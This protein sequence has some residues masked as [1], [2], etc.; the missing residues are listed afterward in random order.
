MNIT[1]STIQY[2]LGNSVKTFKIPKEDRNINFKKWSYN[3]VITYIKLIEQKRNKKPKNKNNKV[4]YAKLIT[5]KDNMIIK[6]KKTADELKTDYV[7][8]VSKYGAESIQAKS[9]L[10]QLN[11]YGDKILKRYYQEYIKTLRPGQEFNLT[12][13]QLTQKLNE[14]AKYY[15]RDLEC[16]RI[17]I[18]NSMARKDVEVERIQYSDSYNFINVLGRGQRMIAGFD[19]NEKLYFNFPIVNK[20]TLEDVINKIKSEVNIKEFKNFYNW[21]DDKS[22]INKKDIDKYKND[23][24][25]DEKFPPL[26]I[27]PTETSIYICGDIFE[28]LMSKNNGEL[29]KKIYY[30]QY[31]NFGG[32]KYFI[33]NNDIIG[34]GFIDYFMNDEIEFNGNNTDIAFISKLIDNILERVGFTVSRYKDIYDSKEDIIG[35]DVKHK[36]EKGDFDKKMEEEDDDKDVYKDDTDE[37][38]ERIKKKIEEYERNKRGQNEKITPAITEFKPFE[39]PK[40]IEPEIITEEIKP[41]E[42]E[43]KPIDPKR[44][45]PKD[46]KNTVE[47][48]P[49][50][51]L[52]PP[53]NPIPPPL[54]VPPVKP[55]TPPVIP[56]VPQVEPI[57]P[58]VIPEVQ[59]VIPQVEDKQTPTYGP[60]IP[61][62]QNNKIK[63]DVICITENNIVKVVGL[64]VM[65]GKKIEAETIYDAFGPS[66]S[67][68]FENC[69]SQLELYDH[70]KLKNKDVNQQLDIYNDIILKYYNY[71]DIE[72]IFYIEY[73]K[74]EA[75]NDL[76]KQLNELDE[77]PEHIINKIESNPK[78]V[79]YNSKQGNGFYNAGIY[80]SI[81]DF[82]NFRKDTKET[83][84]YLL[85]RII[86]L[87]KDMKTV[88]NKLVSNDIR[89][90]LRDKNIELNNEDD[91]D[92]DTGGNGFMC[93]RCGMINPKFF[94]NDYP[95]LSEFREQFSKL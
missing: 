2:I 6:G 23:M 88:K 7:L 10:E 78:K 37:V 51:P 34:V 8:A 66:F 82:I 33:I 77:N 84:Y 64:I 48:T 65:N 13:E 94:K 68:N 3:D 63:I 1:N 11:E 24:I 28:Y 81:K 5:V 91:E 43:E 80:D 79:F 73:E 83:L 31:N 71:D 74:K 15:I 42:E 40:P 87:E 22:V 89:T 86:A 19:D 58:P 49:V 18:Y 95:T 35:T 90:N 26:L 9:I 59:P 53:V 47:D 16:F 36:Y 76:K 57:L 14:G 55:L 70:N 17:K 56:E 45:K 4:K 27:K 62:V 61:Q 25:K 92:F 85:Q 60:I 75:Q 30:C 72:R 39:F 44:I 38:N 20:Y 29:R 21:D 12:E 67:D 52:P 69:H 32:S 54:P 41:K 93:S 46:D 50:K